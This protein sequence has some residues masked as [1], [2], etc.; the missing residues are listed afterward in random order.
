MVGVVQLSI[1]GDDD[2]QR[3]Y[4]QV[5]KVDGFSVDFFFETLLLFILSSDLVDVVLD[6]LDLSHHPFLG[7]GKIILVLLDHIVSSGDDLLK[8]EMLTFNQVGQACVDF[9]KLDVYGCQLFD[10]V[11]HWLDIDN[12]L[13]T[14]EDLSKVNKPDEII[15]ETHSFEKS[16]LFC[17]FLHLCK[18]LS[19]N[20]NEHVHKDNGYDECG[21]K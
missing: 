12:V 17:S 11:L 19:H 16:V 3:L 20:C 7:L 6:R 13:L 1:Q 5:L 4:V 8:G 18:G 2:F 21:N 10:L 9:L 14:R 15:D